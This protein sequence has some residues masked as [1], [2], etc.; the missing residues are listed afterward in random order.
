MERR[1]QLV[2]EGGDE[3]VLEP[4][5]PLGLVARRPLAL[6]ELEP[7]LGDPH[8]VRDVGVDRHRADDTAVEEDRGRGA[9]DVDILAGLGVAGDHVLDRDLAAQSLGEG[10]LVRRHGPAVRAAHVELGAQL[11]DPLAEVGER[12]GPELPQGVFVAP[13]DPLGGAE[14]DGV[15]HAL[16][17]RVQLRRPPLGHLPGMAQ[18]LGGL[19]ALV[20]VDMEPGPLADAA[21][22]VGKRHG[23]GHHVA[24]FAVMA[25]HPVLHLVASPMGEGLEPC[26]TG[27]GAVV[28][29]DGVEPPP[30]AELLEALA[31]EGAPSWLLGL[32]LAGR[33]PVPDHRRDGFDQ[34]AV[35]LLAMVEGARVGHRE[36]ADH[37]DETPS[38][39]KREPFLSQVGAVGSPFQN[40]RRREDIPE[41]DSGVVPQSRQ[42]DTLEIT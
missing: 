4:V 3:I 37:R 42:P 25:A 34:S 40:I 28:R 31:G 15:G 2:R 18:H 19:R 8:P 36:P 24:V 13:R 33:G 17:H 35:A 29:M 11:A 30:P 41:N 1:A 14:V 21:G 20:D 38:R 39:E 10:E 23:A 5:R 16:D 26:L 7:L 27:A 32:E 22:A 6:Q 12:G 9:A